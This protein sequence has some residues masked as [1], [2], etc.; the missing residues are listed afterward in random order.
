MVVHSCFSHQSC[1]PRIDISNDVSSAPNEYR[2]QNLHPWEVDVSTTSIEPYKPFGFSSSR[3]RVLD[4][5]YVKNA[6]RASF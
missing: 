6:L 1:I 3:V 4:F 5:T 2:M